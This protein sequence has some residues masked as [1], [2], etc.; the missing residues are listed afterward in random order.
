M[1]DLV[2]LVYISRSTEAD[3]GE[4]H[5]NLVNKQILSEARIFNHLNNITGILCFANDCYFLIC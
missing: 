5:T 3:K 1:N 2:R 4:E